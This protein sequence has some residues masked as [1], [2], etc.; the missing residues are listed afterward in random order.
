MRSE[1]G[2]EAEGDRPEKEG[3]EGGTVGCVGVVVRERVGGALGV[4]VVASNDDT[5]AFESS[6]PYHISDEQG[7][8][9]IPQQVGNTNYSVHC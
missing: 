5:S 2:F 9:L 8:F 6:A 7:A 4:G 1:L 3:N